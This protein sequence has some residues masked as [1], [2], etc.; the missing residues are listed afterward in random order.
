[1]LTFDDEA[2]TDVARAGGKGASLARM[3]AFGLPVPPGFV[4]EAECLVAAREDRADGRGGVRQHRLERLR[5]HHEPRRHRDAERGHPRERRAL[6]AGE[7]DVGA[8]LVVEE[9]EHV[10][11]RRSR[12]RARGRPSC[13][14]T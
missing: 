9:R 10:S 1:M 7:G 2:C 6:A 13:R 5:R 12:P 11:R 8:A 14:P 3:R 4:V